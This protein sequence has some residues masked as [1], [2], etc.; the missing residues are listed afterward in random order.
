VDVDVAV[1]GGGITGLTAAYLLKQSGLRVAVVD[2]ARLAEVDS[3]HTSAHLTMVTDLRLKDLVDAF[4]KDHARAAWDAGAAAI[5]QI[6]EIAA[7]EKANCLFARVSGYLTTSPQPTDSDI[8]LLRGEFDL[9]RELGFD[10]SFLQSAPLFGRP[11]VEFADQARFHPVRYLAALAR[12]IDGNGSFVFEHSNVESIDADPMRVSIA[13]GGK[14]SC[15]DVVI[16]THNPIIGTAGWLGA[17]LLQTK[18]SLY[19][20]Y[21]VAGRTKPG[22]VP[23]GLYWDTG[24]PYLYVRVEP[25]HTF[26]LVIVGGAD[27]KTGQETQTDEHHR[28]LENVAR[29]LVPGFELSHRWSG[30]VIETNDGLPFIGEM[31][32]HQYAA[33]GFGGNGL[34]F[35]TVGAMIIADRITEQANPWAELFDL[36]RTKIRGGIWDYLKE[37]KDFP[38]YMLRDRLAPPDA[39]SLRFVRRGEGKIAD[40][41]GKRVAAYRN[42][43]GALTLLS[44][45]CTHLGCI[46]AW[47]PTESTWDCP[48]HGSRFRA[49]GEV[50]SGPAESPL[51]PADLPKQ[52]N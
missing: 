51:Q 42:D 22:V 37:N 13:G 34:T 20:S 29:E 43:R 40:V 9:A 28:Q 24:D 12:A 6:E 19:T 48:C 49:T 18:L 10:V 45:V 31:A 1:V 47:N 32:P 36:G 7:G 50:L 39:R 30:Q 5:D 4:G 33:T 8:E 38:Y 26:D 14:I 27:H 21:V 44:P 25:H 52:G 15:N 41:Q 17:T 23:D 2:R 3:G 35:G 11:A 16:A 46:V